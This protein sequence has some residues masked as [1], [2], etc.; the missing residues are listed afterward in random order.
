MKKLSSIYKI[1]L[2]H[3]ISLLVSFILVIS[4]T[5]ST[6]ISIKKQTGII[7]RELIEKNKIVSQHL[8]AS[9]NSAFWSLNW[10]FVEKQIHKLTELKDITFIDLIKPDGEVYMS[11]GNKMCD[12]NFLTP[13]MMNTE[14][15]V[16][17]ET[18]CPVTGKNIKLI[19]TP[20]KVGDS[21][22]ILTTGFSLEEVEKAKK[23]IIINNML[24]GFVIFLFSILGSFF[25]TRGIIK[26]AEQ[27][28][29]GTKEIGK[30]NLDY[31]INIK[32]HDE[33]GGLA[34]SFNKMAEDLK[35]TTASR[36]SLAKEIK[37]RKQAEKA[38]LESEEKFRSIVENSHAGIF[39]VDNSYKF[40]YANKKFCRISGYSS[41]EIIGSDFRKLLDEENR[42]LVAKRYIQRQKGENVPSKYK[43]NLIRKDNAK[44]RMEIRS[45]VIMGPDGMP[46]TISQILDITDQ[47]QLEAQLQ[48]AQK[49]EAIGTLAG[50]VA[51][52][53]NNVL[54]GIVSYPELL[55][56]K[57]PEDSPLRK[58]ILTIQKSGQKAAAIVQDLLTLARRGVSTTEVVGL[59]NIISDYLKSPEYNKLRSFN[60]DIT[61]ETKLETNLLNIMGSSVHVYKTIMNLVSNA[62]ESMPDGGEIFIS[63]ENHYLDMPV[64][65]YEHI[66]EGDYVVFSISDTGTG[67]APEDIEKIFEPFYTN[68]KMGRSGTGLG[69]AVVWGTVKDHNGYIDIQSRQLKG[70]TVKL[71]F[72]VTRINPAKEKAELSIENYMGRGEKI[73][74]VDDSEEQR[75]IAYNMLE[76]LNYSVV[77][78]SGGEEAVD[79]MRN[80]SADLMVLD[81]IMAPGIDGLETYRQVL[82]IHPGQKAIIASGFSET[83]RVKEAQRLGAGAYVKKPY[84]LEQIALAVKAEL[85]KK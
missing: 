61:L 65:G 25:F 53:L 31:R 51:H 1:G 79:Y 46:Q 85:E 83:D 54:S 41:E 63:T 43:F 18:L 13:D 34:V 58:P 22:W 33:I 35:K 2:F 57:L 29:K 10:L 70:T 68:K 84:M 5:L 74:V 80:N 82:K 55:L 56:M 62:A 81:M 72:P 48:R 50:G 47:R 21:K 3:K 78:V 45:T 11:S 26:P 7:T 52:D 77:T 9:V 42:N 30:G 28:A 71:Y 40:I 49:M 36:D 75:K 20:I 16:V 60:A 73:L 32:S 64:K 27:L 66:K 8:A 76:T 12:E 4:I 19:I 24:V 67:I 37:E 6:A 14:E 69:M 38:L 17:E 44:R 59:N 39:M 15:Q 23:S